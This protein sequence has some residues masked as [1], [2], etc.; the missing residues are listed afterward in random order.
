MASNKNLNP[1]EYKKNY[2]ESG[3]WDKVTIYAKKAGKKVIE[4][5]LKM[6][7]SAQDPNTP[8]KA[9]AIIYGALGYFILPIDVIPDV[10]PVVGYTD[11]LGV[12]V[13]ALTTVAI[14]I[15]DEHV[16]KAKETMTRWF[17]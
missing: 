2:S 5:A 1:E 12:L 9:K 11:D 13:T 14:H 17:G 3:F 6:Y 7:Y 4:P 15:T 8:T 16:R 10:A